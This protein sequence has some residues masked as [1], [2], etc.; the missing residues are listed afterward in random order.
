M[1]EVAAMKADH[2]NS[3]WRKAFDYCTARGNFGDSEQFVRRVN[4]FKQSASK[5]K[6]PTS[7]SP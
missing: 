5:V 7:Q 6:F 2:F 4:H 3:Q 1:L